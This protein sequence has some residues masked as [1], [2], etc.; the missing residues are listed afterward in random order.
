MTIILEICYW[1]FID[2]YTIVKWANAMSICVEECLEFRRIYL[3][4][5]SNSG[6]SC[7]SCTRFLWYHPRQPS[8]CW[9]SFALSH[10]SRHLL[11]SLVV[12]SHSSGISLMTTHC[13]RLRYNLDSGTDLHN[14][15]A[16]YQAGVLR[17]GAGCNSSNYV[18]IPF[19][20]VFYIESVT[21]VNGG[22]RNSE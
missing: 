9:P 16:S 21:F 6:I 4:D 18:A 13:N 14:L 1:I 15:T 7:D 20:A 10:H 11:L 17:I 8:S 22:S 19:H 2:L 5:S 12:S 3:P